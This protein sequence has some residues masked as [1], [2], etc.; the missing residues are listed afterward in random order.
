MWDPIATL[1]LT[2]NWQLTPPVIGDFFRLRYLSAVWGRGLIAQVPG[3]GPLELY[4]VRR[5]YG[6]EDSIYQLIAPPSFSS[7]S[8]GLLQYSG[9]GWQVA[10]DVWT[11]TPEPTLAQIQADLQRIEAKIDL[12]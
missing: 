9:T 3:S 7:R 6:R 1:T 8:I 12:L 10:V 11:G 4:G 2:N 5:I